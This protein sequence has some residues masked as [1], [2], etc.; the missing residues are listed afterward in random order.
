MAQ[1]VGL[2]ENFW[3]MIEDTVGSAYTLQRKRV[4]QNLN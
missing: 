2:R 3:T 4:I 1:E